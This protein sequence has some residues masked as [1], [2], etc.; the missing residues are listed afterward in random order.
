MADE[1]SAEFVLKQGV[2][3][4]L[5]GKSAKEAIEMGKTEI[6]KVYYG[7]YTFRV[8]PLIARSMKRAA[9]WPRVHF[10]QNQADKKYAEQTCMHFTRF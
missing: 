8:V 5:M 2:S 4:D 9:E 3:N 7:V 10:C 6:G 1:I